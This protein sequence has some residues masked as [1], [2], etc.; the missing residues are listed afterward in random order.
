MDEQMVWNSGMPDEHGDAC[1][2][3]G[4]STDYEHDHN[5]NNK[6]SHNNEDDSTTLPDDNNNYSNM[7]NFYKNIR[8]IHSMDNM[9]RSL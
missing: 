5:H 7:D 9:D 2:D 1:S 4:A 8:R 6:Q 3:H